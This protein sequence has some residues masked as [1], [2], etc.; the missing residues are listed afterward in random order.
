MRNMGSLA[1]DVPWLN[2]SVVQGV[3]RGIISGHI[4][5]YAGVDQHLLAVNHQLVR[6][7]I[8]AVDGTAAS[9]GRPGCFPV[10]AVAFHD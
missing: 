3:I 5:R 4:F 1:R 9:Y 8:A 10:G 2:A 7:E 6:Y